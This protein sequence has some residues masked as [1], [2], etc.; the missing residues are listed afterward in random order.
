MRRLSKQTKRKFLMISAIVLAAGESKRMGR[1]NKLLLPFDGKALVAHL[2]DAILASNVRETLVILGYEAAFV[3]NALRSRKVRFVENQH[4]LQGMTTSIQAG[5][6]EVDAESNG[7]MVCL[8]D[9]P[10]VQT[11]E[12][13]R[14]ILE[15]EEASVTNRKQIVLPSYQGHRGNPVIFSV[16]YKSR[17]LKHREENGCRGLIRQYKDQVQAVEMPTSHVLTDIDTKTD[18][19]ILVSGNRQEHNE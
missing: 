5:V 9:L 13:N 6:R 19:E 17:I 4:Y 15:F 10:L 18:Y 8:S 2:V 16:Y 1:P 7:I 3:K 12:L 11:E 14:L